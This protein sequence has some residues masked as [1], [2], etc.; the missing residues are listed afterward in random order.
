MLSG[1]QAWPVYQEHLEGLVREWGEE[2][3]APGLSYEQTEALRQARIRVNTEIV[4]LPEVAR[5]EKEE[6]ENGTDR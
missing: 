3:L 5:R 4:S 1:S 2:A 6:E